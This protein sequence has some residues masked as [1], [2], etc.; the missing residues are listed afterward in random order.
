[1]IDQ[2]SSVTMKAC[3]VMQKISFLFYV[4]HEFLTGSVIHEC[5]LPFA[6]LKSNV[7]LDQKEIFAPGEVNEIDFY[8]T[9][10]V[11]IQVAY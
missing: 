7:S 2:F 6:Q 5:V 8:Q 4:K 11:N 10:D 1:M 3:N 9:Y